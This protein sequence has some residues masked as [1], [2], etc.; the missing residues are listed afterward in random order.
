MLMVMHVVMK[1]EDFAAVSYLYPELDN[2]VPE[3]MAGR[4]EQGG[5][6]PCF[7]Q[8]GSLHPTGRNPAV[9]NYLSG[10]RVTAKQNRST[11]DKKLR[12]LFTPIMQLKLRTIVGGFLR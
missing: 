11:Q 12:A 1:K 6:Q 3:G 7:Q 4:T 10:M 2:R 8:A 9:K 5:E